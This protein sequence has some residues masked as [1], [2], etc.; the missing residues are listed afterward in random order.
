VPVGVVGGGKE[1][2][3]G[4]AAFALFLT[5]G[6]LAPWLVAALRSWDRRFNRAFFFTCA[7]RRFIFIEFRLSCFP[8][9]RKMPLSPM[10]RQARARVRDSEGALDRRPVPAGRFKNGVPESGSRKND[11]SAEPP[12]AERQSLGARLVLRS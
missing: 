6:F 8:T 11:E 1:V 4:G 3:V 5:A 10:N 12:P 7:L 9:A 2:D